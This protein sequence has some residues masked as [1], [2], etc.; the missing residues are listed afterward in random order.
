[1][2]SRIIPTAAQDLKVIY[3]IELLQYFQRLNCLSVRQL[4]NFTI[5]AFFFWIHADFVSSLFLHSFASGSLYL[6]FL[7]LPALFCLFASFR[8][9]F[10]F[11][12]MSNDVVLMI[13]RQMI[14]SF[15]CLSRR[16]HPR[17]RF[18]GSGS[19]PPDV[20]SCH[21]AGDKNG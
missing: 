16:S 7:L 4:C 3:W 15:H 21:A 13:V 9:F 18:R 1:M 8:S 12:L 11:V 10:C 17:E 19:P 6:S 20:K 14:P 2:N 5:H